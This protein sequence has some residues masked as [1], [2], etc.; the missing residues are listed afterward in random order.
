[1]PPLLDLALDGVVAYISTCTSMVTAHSYWLAAH[2]GE[3]PAAERRAGGYID[4]AVEGL[5][6]QLISVVPWNHYQALVDLFMVWLTQAVHQ[7]KA[8][9]RRSNSPPETVHH[10]H[11]LV[12]FVHL[13]VHPRLRSIDLST[14]P[15]VLRDALY[16]Q[17][18]HLTGL[19][20]LHLGSGS[21]EAARQRGFLSLRHLTSLT[22][23]TLG[24]DCTNDTLAVVGQNCSL[25]RHLDICSSGGVTEQ[26]S[27]W[28]LL[29]RRLERLN[30]FQTS[31]SVAG[32]AQL[33]QGLP[34]LAT[35]GRC[36]ATGQ[37]MEYIDK[38]RSGSV[39]L[40]LAE[41]H[42]R[43]M[44]YEQ[45][46]LYVKM[47]PGTTKVNLY[48]DE[49]LGHLLSP[50]HTL[51]SL[52]E[53]KLLACNFYSDR[54]DVLVREQGPHLTLLHL[55]HVDELDMAAL[56]LIA[57]CCPNL[58]KLVFF[59]CDFVDNFG[60]A[61][62][63]FPAPPFRALRSLV[64]VSESAPSV[65]EFLLVT[66]DLLTSVQF[67]STAW[68]NDQIVEA[69]L[70]RKAL[71]HVEE[72]RILRSYELSMAAVH[73]LIAACPSLRVLAEMEGWEGIGQEELLALRQQ[74]RRNNWE[75][76][77]FIAW[78]TG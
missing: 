6:A 78:S 16:K 49:D 64:C 15:K 40:P 25:L 60:W 70:R 54:V 37:V 71:R 32:Y 30:L 61:P 41:L 58:E 48:V 33:L 75:L 29:C 20:H 1:V 35:V 14:L 50:L 27:S 68:F 8:I 42:S 56:A 11:V 66:A 23:L 12:R 31:E 51:T 28:L 67:G 76:D 46:Q 47:C 62:E 63:P 36:D 77:T 9:Y 4:K 69:V 73:R 74:V 38:H 18:G 55:E 3:T 5:R 10:A 53:L 34:G 13:V 22:S 7:S 39:T 65:I 17:L 24:S 59:S 21:G 19:K 45:L 52:K 44:S 57:L 72:I 26:G 2:G 43:D